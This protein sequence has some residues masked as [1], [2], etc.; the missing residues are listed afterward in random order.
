MAPQT[1]VVA[2]EAHHLGEELTWGQ[3]FSEAFAAA[4]RWLLLSGTP[5]RSD[6]TSIPGV[7]YSEAGVAIADVSYSY[8]EA[9]RDGVCRPM[10]FVPFDGEFSWRTDGVR[11]LGELRA[12]ASAPAARPSLPDRARA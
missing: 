1:L 9:V 12:G 3:G 8:A 6:K 2:D 10:V 5:F 4:R 7:R 11:A